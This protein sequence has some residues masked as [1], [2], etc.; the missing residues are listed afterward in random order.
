MPHLLFRII[1]SNYFLAQVLFFSYKL[2]FLYALLT[3]GLLVAEEL[4]DF[5]L[6]A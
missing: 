1:F 4:I 5:K 6:E 2:S 3:F